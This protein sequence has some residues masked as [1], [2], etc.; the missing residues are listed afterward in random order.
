MFQDCK[1]GSTSNEKWQLMER[2]FYLY[3]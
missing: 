2:I 3:E 1:P